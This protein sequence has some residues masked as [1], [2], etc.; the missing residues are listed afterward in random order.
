MKKKNPETIIVDGRV[1]LKNPGKGNCCSCGN[2]LLKK[3]PRC[4]NAPA[5]AFDPEYWDFD[6]LQPL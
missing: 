6:S 4:S 3:N 5:L 2:P 1:Q